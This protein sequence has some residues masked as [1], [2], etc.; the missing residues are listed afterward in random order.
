V[1]KLIQHMFHAL[2]EKKKKKKPDLEPP[3]ESKRGPVRP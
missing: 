2:N 1:E 3:R